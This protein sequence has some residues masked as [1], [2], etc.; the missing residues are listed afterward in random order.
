MTV[1]PASLEIYAS[2]AQLSSTQGSSVTF[3]V[4]AKDAANQAMPSQPVSFTATSGVLQGALPTPS[5][6]AAGE[7]I[8]KV[9][10]LPGADPTNRTVVVTATSGKVTKSVTIPI[11]GTTITLSGD[12]SVVQGSTLTYSA[13]AVDSAGKAIPGA[14]LTVTSN[15]NSVTPSTTLTTNSLGVANFSYVA[16]NGGLD[17]LTVA[18]LGATATSSIS[19]S[20][21]DFRFTSPAANTSIEVGTSPSVQVQLRSGGLAVQNAPISFATTRGTVSAPSAM[22]NASGVATVQVSSNTSGPATITART[23]SGAQVT[24]PVN[25]IATTPASLVLQAN[26]GAVFPNT[27]G[28]QTNQSTME[29]VVRDSVGNPVAGKTVNFVSLSDP[30]GGS[31]SPG[32]GVTDSNGYVSAQFIPGPQTTA[33]DGVRVQATVAG[34]AV[35]GTASLTISGQALFISIASGNEITN[36]NPDT[37]EKSFALYV[38]D[39]NGAPV[40]NRSVQLSVSPVE[41]GKGSLTKVDGK[42]EAS[43]AATCPNEDANRNGVL[44]SGEDTNGDGELTPGLPVVVSPGTVTTDSVGIAKF[45]LRYGENFAPWVLARITARATVGGTESSKSALYQLLGSVA[46]FSGDGIPAGVVSP[47]GQ[48]ANCNDAD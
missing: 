28:S 27:A 2:T 35:S 33:V 21:E 48:S 45:V 20:S 41:Y 25:F 18:G 34:T 23:G 42:W 19:V 9:S 10:L 11:V 26:P 3:T 29:A 17:T 30:S 39:A 6:G 37:Y 4:L 43:V 38:T 15:N 40:P 47:F 1:S 46:D 5:T 32:S 36:Y 44:D 12:S 22:T 7:P 16:L 24:L 14:T 8:T 31:L 13:K